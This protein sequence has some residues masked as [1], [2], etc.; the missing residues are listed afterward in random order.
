MPHLSLFRMLIVNSG[1]PP[2]TETTPKKILAAR[3]RL[4]PSVSI[5]ESQIIAECF[6]K[7]ILS[8]FFICGFFTEKLRNEMRAMRLFENSSQNA[9]FLKRPLHVKL[10]LANLCWQNSNWCV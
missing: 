3:C 1:F 4:R 9:A 7:S 5:T 8:E 10:M 2:A 6:L